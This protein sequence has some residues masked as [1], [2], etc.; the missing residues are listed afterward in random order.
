MLINF[1]A[2]TPNM[3]YAAFLYDPIEHGFC[4]SV[5]FEAAQ[6]FY[7][8]EPHKASGLPQVEPEPVVIDVQRSSGLVGI[9]H[10][11]CVPGHCARISVPGVLDQLHMQLGIGAAWITKNLDLLADNLL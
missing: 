2:M 5:P 4:Q 9:V 3:V 11:K 6:D 1:P 10:C 7:G 8:L